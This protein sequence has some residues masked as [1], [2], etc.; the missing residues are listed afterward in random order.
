MVFIHT[1]TRTHTHTCSV[2]G[3]RK[4][5]LHRDG[6]FSFRQIQ[7]VPW[8]MAFTNDAKLVAGCF[9]DGSIPMWCTDT[10]N[11]VHTVI[12]HGEI[13]ARCIDLKNRNLLADGVGVWQHSSKAGEER[14]VNL[15]NFSRFML[16]RTVCVVKFSRDGSKIASGSFDR[17]VRVFEARTGTQLL[18]LASGHKH[19]VTCVAWSSDNRLIASGD[20]E[21]AICMWDAV[22]G[23]QVSQPLRGHEHCVTCLEFNTQTSLLVSAS[24]DHTVIIWDLDEGRNA[25][26]RGRPLQGHTNAVMSV[27]LSP[28][29]RFLA[30]GSWDKSVRVW[31]V[32]TGRPCKVLEGLSAGVSSAVWTP[33]G[34]RIVSV[35]LD[36]FVHHWEAEE[37]VCS[38]WFC[39]V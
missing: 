22:S 21:R 30:S 38:L 31:E 7:N 25:T 5:K 35:S 6:I 29:G 11:H 24:F 39:V 23:I 17:T 9:H 32:S 15:W 12:S 4:I 13:G 26:M 33:D 2:S 3:M 27:S 19:C 16:P 36:C 1:H 37:Q 8:S 10:G 20:D 34:Q 18:A 14:F 28:D